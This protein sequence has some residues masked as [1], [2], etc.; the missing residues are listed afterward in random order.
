MEVFI[1]Q[2]SDDLIY[3]SHSIIVGVYNIRDKSK[4]EYK[5]CQDVVK[6]LLQFVQNTID[7]S[8][9]TYWR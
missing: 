7:K 2:I 9:F 4:E 5:L 8:L 6:N 3:V 1:K